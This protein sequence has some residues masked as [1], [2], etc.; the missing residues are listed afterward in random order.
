MIYLA[1]FNKSHEEIIQALEAAREAI[2]PVKHLWST[3]LPY[4]NVQWYRPI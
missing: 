1:R 4:T 3:V 2:T